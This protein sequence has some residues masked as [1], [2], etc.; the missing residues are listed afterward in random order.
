QRG[1][2]A[3]EDQAQAVVGELIVR[4]LRSSL[5]L[6]RFEALE[7]GPFLQQRALAAET[8]DRLVAGYS[9]DPRARVVR[10]P[11]ARPALEGDDERL[12]EA[13]AVQQVEASQLLLRLGE[14]TVGDQPLVALADLDRRRRRAWLQ[15]L[16]GHVDAGLRDLAGELVP[17]LHPR[18]HLLRADVVPT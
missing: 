16:A 8:I 5:G 12:V 11:V 3:G 2:A 6:E 13:A 7:D 15:A 10:G 4:T 14:R 17:G 18:P 9:G 1:V